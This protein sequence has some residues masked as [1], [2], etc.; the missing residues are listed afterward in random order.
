MR[1]K[2]PEEER[3]YKTWQWF[4]WWVGVGKGGMGDS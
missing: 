1:R 4:R 3:N 2:I